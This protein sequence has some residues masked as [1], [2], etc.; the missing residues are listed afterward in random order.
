MSSA[1][2]ALWC[3]LLLISPAKSQDV[4]VEE[5]VDDFMAAL[6]ESE[7]DMSS[8]DGNVTLLATKLVRWSGCGPAGSARRKAIYAGWQQSWKLMN[9]IF[10]VANKGINWNEAA[11]VEYLGPPALNGDKRGDMTGKT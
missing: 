10:D 8:F 9:N 4:S 2:V 6:E 3:L 1:F 11:A 5:A 7:Y